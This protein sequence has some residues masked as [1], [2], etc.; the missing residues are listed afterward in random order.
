MTTPLQIAQQDMRTGHGYGSTGVLSSGLVWLCAALA[1]MMYGVTTG[2]WTLIIGGMIIFPLSM[3]IGKLTGIPGKHDPNNPLGKSAMEG[4]VWMLMCI[5]MAYGLS[6]VR[7]EWFFQGM[8]LIIG[9]RYLTFATLYGMKVYWLLGA[10]LGAAAFI[11]FAMQA[12]A[13]YSALA[14]ALIEILMGTV[15]YILFRKQRGKNEAAIPD[16]HT[17]GL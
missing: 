14:G 10:V 15:L 2:I 5:P 13:F 9:G 8:L 11:L 4:T 12:V 7:P 17:S 16:S 6:L 3:L 1:V